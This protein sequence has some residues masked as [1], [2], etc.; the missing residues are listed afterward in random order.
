MTERQRFREADWLELGFR[1][2]VDF[3]AAGL[4]VERLC[5][6]AGR[7]RGSFYHHFRDHDAFVRNLMERWKKRHTDDVIAQVER[8]AER[9]GDANARPQSLHELAVHLDHRLDLAVRLFAQ[10]HPVAAIYLKRV[11]TERLDYL[12]RLYRETTTLPSTLADEVA[13]LEYAAFVGA[14]V[15]QPDART[16]APNT[17][18]F[19]FRAAHRLAE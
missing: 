2:L 14:Q 7:T 13:W 8:R 1:Q 15:L 9:T 3:G 10:T 11:D 17:K 12:K 4:T 6:A 5:E 18:N 19:F 16:D